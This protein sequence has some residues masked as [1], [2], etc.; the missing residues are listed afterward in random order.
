MKYGG[1]FTT[2]T[3]NFSEVMGFGK[4]VFAGIGATAASK[5]PLQVQRRAVRDASLT[6]RMIVLAVGRYQRG[7][8]AGHCRR[9]RDGRRL[10]RRRREGEMIAR[11]AAAVTFGID[12]GSDQW[13]TKE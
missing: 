4:S 8:P 7:L 9:S 13:L 3:P 6:Q 5:A 12:E 11:A 2:L 1:V 10:L